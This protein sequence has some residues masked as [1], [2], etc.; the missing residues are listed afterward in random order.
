MFASTFWKPICPTYP[1]I[2][3]TGSPSCIRVHQEEQRRCAVKA[4]VTTRQNSEARASS[5]RGACVSW[6]LATLVPVA[7]K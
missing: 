1:A 2:V 6:L 4:K 3:V 7:Q 5:S